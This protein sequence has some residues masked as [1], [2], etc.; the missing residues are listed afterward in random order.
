VFTFQ[1]QLRSCERL[2]LANIWDFL[3]ER[4]LGCIGILKDWLMQALVVAARSAAPAL[5]LAVLERTALSG[6]QCEKMLQDAR[7]GEARLAD[8]DN[9][10]VRL[11]RL[12]NLPD[13]MIAPAAA[14][15][16]TPD[17]PRVGRRTPGVRHPRRDQIGLPHQVGEMQV[18]HA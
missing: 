3:Y 11:R 5:S 15:A 9:T 16:I 2:D 4:S 8:N 13:H 1:K 18:A 12:L 14:K 6:S 7:E 10:R 17:G